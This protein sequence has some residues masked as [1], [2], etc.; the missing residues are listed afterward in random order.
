MQRLQ[1]GRERS[2]LRLPWTHGRHD[3]RRADA[4]SLGSTRRRSV[5]TGIR[6]RQLGSRNRQQ[7]GRRSRCYST[8]AVLLSIVSV[9]NNPVFGFGGEYRHLDWQAPAMYLRV[10]YHDYG[11]RQSIK[12]ERQVILTRPVSGLRKQ[13]CG[14]I[15]RGWRSRGS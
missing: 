14:N 13:G 6:R 8:L 12:C 4:M 3:L 2:H 9:Y 7:W 1:A 5:C 11:A 10:V 15:R